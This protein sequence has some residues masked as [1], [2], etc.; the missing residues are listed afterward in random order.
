M[1]L[2]VASEFGVP[3]SWEKFLFCSDIWSLMKQPKDSECKG[4]ER[5]ALGWR[6]P[7]IHRSS[8]QK[9]GWTGELEVLEGLGWV[10]PMSVAVAAT[11]GL[12]AS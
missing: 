2:R 6:R 1:G 7:P 9:L 3:V 4:E 10:A 11:L 8:S 12:S 5:G